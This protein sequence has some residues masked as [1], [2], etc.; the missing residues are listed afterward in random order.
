MTLVKN[1]LKY[2]VAHSRD[3]AGVGIGVTN[4]GY[5]CF[6]VIGVGSLVYIVETAIG[7]V[8]TT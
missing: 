6:Y 3:K 1:L 7:D 2:L 5:A 4:N 8:V